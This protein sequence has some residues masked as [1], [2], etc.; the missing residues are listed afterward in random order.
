MSIPFDY[1]QQGLMTGAELGGQ[2]R[3]RR[4]GRQ[5]GGMLQQG[6]YAGASG[7]A[8]GEGDLR[9]GAAI[10]EMGREQEGRD[11]GLAVAGALY[12]EQPDI[13]GAR[14]AAQGDPDMMRQV[15]EFAQ[16]A[17]EQ[18]RATAAQN[19]ERLAIMGLT[20]LQPMPVEQRYQ[21]ALQLAQQYGIPPEQI[22]PVITDEVLSAWAAQ[23][24]GL[25]DFLQ[26]QDRE[27]DNRRQADQ[28][29]IQRGNLDLARQREGR[30]GAGRPSGGGGSRRP[31]ASG[32]GAPSAPR[33]PSGSGPW[34]RFQ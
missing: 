27:T 14:T 23:T 5:I 19:F 7:V 11:R 25:A 16:T 6:D 9:T 8:Y 29:E 33:P 2:M 30:M 3:Q 26:H 34:S 1:M 20:T 21:A 13:E 22:P 15:A 28:V 32:G 17:S 10:G 31:A 4:T 24:M 12:G 18:E